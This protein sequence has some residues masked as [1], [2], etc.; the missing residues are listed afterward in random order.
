MSEIHKLISSICNKEEWSHQ[1]SESIVVPVYN[2][3]NKTDC[4][5]CLWDITA[6]NF[7]Q[8]WHNTSTTDQICYILQR[9]TKTGE[10]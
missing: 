9:L 7:V 3:G 6:I 10:Q 1:Q 5:N 4:G 8:I 2:K